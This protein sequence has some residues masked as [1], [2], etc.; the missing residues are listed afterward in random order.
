MKD[1]FN[2]WNNCF[3]ATRKTYGELGREN[4]SFDKADTT[5]LLFLNQQKVSLTCKMRETPKLQNTAPTVVRGQPFHI[6]T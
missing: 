2:R 3:T 4:N 6:I 5:S 1:Q